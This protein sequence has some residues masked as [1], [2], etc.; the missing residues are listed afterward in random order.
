MLKKFWKKNKES[1]KWTTTYMQLQNKEISIRQFVNINADKTLYYSTP[2]G[3]DESGNP[4]LWILSTP[5]DELKYYPA[6]SDI[7]ACKSFFPSIGRSQFIIIE[8][9][10][11]NVLNSMDDPLLKEFGVVVDPHSSFPIAIPPGIRAE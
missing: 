3:E 8:G 6:F 9:D 10:L 11:R 7:T 1:D 5:G 2:A 4:R